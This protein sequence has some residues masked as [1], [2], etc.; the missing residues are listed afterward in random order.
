MQIQKDKF[1]I[2]GRPLRRHI[3]SLLCD[4]DINGNPILVPKFSS[5]GRMTDSK[6]RSG[7][8]QNTKSFFQTF[9]NDFTNNYD[10]SEFVQSLPSIL[11]K[12]SPRCSKKAFEQNKRENNLGTPT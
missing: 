5:R 3:K 7:N 12:T 1:K 8:P 2:K 6:G 10:M 4:K 9:S 11:V